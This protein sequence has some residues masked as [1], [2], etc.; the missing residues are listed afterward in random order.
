MERCQMFGILA[1]RRGVLGL[2]SLLSAALRCGHVASSGACSVL[3]SQ[4]KA[5]E[6]LCGKLLMAQLISFKTLCR[7]FHVSGFPFMATMQCGQGLRISEWAYAC[8]FR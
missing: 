8:P 4:A 2:L 3:T 5:I 6:D 1:S 7:S